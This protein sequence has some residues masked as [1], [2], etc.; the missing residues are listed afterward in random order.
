MLLAG[1]HASKF[2][3]WLWRLTASCLLI[4]L[5]GAC[6]QK[7]TLL[8]AAQEEERGLTS[9]SHAIPLL[10]T[11]YHAGAL[12]AAGLGLMPQ[13]LDGFMHG[14]FQKQGLD[15]Q[16]EVRSTVDPLNLVAGSSLQPSQYRFYHKG[17]PIYG[18]SVKATLTDEGLPFVA[19]E[20]PN[21]GSQQAA[22]DPSGAEP[23]WQEVVSRIQ[24]KIGS[25]L[26]SSSFKLIKHEP[27]FV[28]AEGRLVRCWRFIIRVKDIPYEGVADAKNFYHFFS[29]LT[30]IDG[31]ANIF[32]KNPLDG[33]KQTFPLKDLKGDGTLENKFFKTEMALNKYQ[34]AKS[35]N[36]VFNYEPQSPEFAETSLFTN[37]SRVVDWL[38]QLGYEVG[39][40]KKI[41]L[42]VHAAP[43]GSI[44]NANFDTETG[45]IIN[46]GDG[47]G[48]RL[49]N[50]P[51]DADVVNHEFNHY[52][53]YQSVKDIN[54]LPA[55][56]IHEALADALTFIRTGD[57]C[58]GESLCTKSDECPCVSEQCLRSGRNNKVWNDSILGEL[59]K[60][61]PTTSPH[62]ESQFLSG[63][64]W[65]LITVDQINA[66]LVA[67]TILRAIAY[68]P[69]RTEFKHLIIALMQADQDL[70]KGANCTRIYNR[71]AERGLY[72][73]IDSFG[74]GNRSNSLDAGAGARTKF[75]AITKNF[76]IATT[77][78]SYELSQRRSG[79]ASSKKT[80]RPLC[81]QLTGGTSTQGYPL[82]LIMWAFPLVV[83]LV[84]RVKKS[85]ILRFKD[86]VL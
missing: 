32:T 47:D 18:Y 61:Q 10:L 48:I 21:L 53:V 29:R 49:K 28:L 9:P 85:S 84:W 76:P 26:G 77:N 11:P 69:E 50:L 60:K 15:P 51:L 62:Q 66:E 65:D 55:L 54:Y 45:D 31:Q 37:A 23:S 73:H 81:G 5:S 17:I 46:I 4:L 20:L 30:D 75:P 19:G 1:F 8:P 35:P 36:H 79:S 78:E 56:M 6:R 72:K 16:I 68:L 22:H 82:S 70:S 33:Q 44:N 43:G 34:R 86:R 74:C 67:K 13:T 40:I 64:I 57:A 2:L 3:N 38:G 41:T 80:S 71:A 25:E 58:I 42:V 12:A 63:M 24:E 7:T 59:K 14:V 27:Q 39:R 83:M 52:L